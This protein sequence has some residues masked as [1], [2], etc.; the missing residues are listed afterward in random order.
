MKLYLVLETDIA[1]NLKELLH[2]LESVQRP[3]RR[4]ANER[5]HEKFRMFNVR[6][7]LMLQIWISRFIVF[8]YFV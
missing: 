5:T 2:Q 8:V 6:H 4:C 7:E 3:S 1:Q